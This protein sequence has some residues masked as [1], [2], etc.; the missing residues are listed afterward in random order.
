MQ[1]EKPAH[2]LERMNDL[3]PILREHG[4]LA[5]L[6]V[7]LTPL[8]QV[9][10]TY[11]SSAYAEVLDNATTLILELSGTELRGTDVFTSSDRDVLASTDRGGDGFLVFLSAP[12]RGGAA[13]LNELE[14]LAQRIENYLNASLARMASPG[15]VLVN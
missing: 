14:T 12:E 5:A 2:Y 15:P 9:E 8:G 7:D 13:R 4:G 10:L 11:G 1:R 3:A 6:L